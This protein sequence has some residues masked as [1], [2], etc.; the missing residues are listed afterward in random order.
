MVPD[1]V[2]GFGLYNNLLQIQQAGGRRWATERPP[3]PPPDRAAAD[4]GHP[5]KLPP[6]WGGARAWP[7]MLG[8]VR[9]RSPA[10]KRRGRGHRRG[11]GGADRLS[12]LGEAAAAARRVLQ[13]R[14]SGGARQRA[15]DVGERRCRARARAAAAAA[16]AT[17]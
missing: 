11:G 6:M 9:V 1:D 15:E 8:G 5:G 17:T 2:L 3:P 14:G 16:A 4:V 7:P 10:R 13:C 12:T